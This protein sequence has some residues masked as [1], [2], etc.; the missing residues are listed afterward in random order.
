MKFPSYFDAVN[1][2]EIVREYPLGPAFLET[3]SRTS[4]EQLRELQN[5]R[6]LQVMKR[7]WQVPFYQRLWKGAGLWPGDIRSLDDIGR[8]PAYSKADLMR[9]IEERPPFSSPPAP[10]QRR[11]P[12]PRWS[13]CATSASPCWWASPIT[14]AISPRSRATCASSRVATSGAA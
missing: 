2:S 5:R 9:S 4:L 11:A 1:Y 13:T 7:A 6:F 8:L 10:A 12:R 14:S 3:F